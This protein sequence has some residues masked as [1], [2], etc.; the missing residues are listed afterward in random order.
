MKS[1]TTILVGFLVGIAVT[2][3]VAVSLR[4]ANRARMLGDVILPT[5]VM[6]NDI[7]RVSREGKNDLV[8]RKLVVLGQIFEDFKNKGTTPEMS[9]SKITELK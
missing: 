9:V 5:Q 2:S 7:L 1:K 8:E 6:I 3:F 4:N